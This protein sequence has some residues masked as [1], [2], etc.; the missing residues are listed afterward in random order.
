MF[1][2]SSPS[3]ED[4]KGKKEGMGLSVS[5]MGGICSFLFAA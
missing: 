2:S 5:I 4:E 3:M 1:V